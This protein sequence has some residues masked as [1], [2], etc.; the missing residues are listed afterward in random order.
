[1]RLKIIFIK[2]S[3]LLPLTAAPQFL[4]AKPDLCS[5]L[6]LTPVELTKADLELFK[7]SKTGPVLSGG[8]LSD[9]KNE[10]INQWNVYFVR[11]GDQ[12]CYDSPIK[13]MVG[14]KERLNTIAAR[15]MALGDVHHP[16]QIFFIC[17]SINYGPTSQLGEKY[18]KEIPLDNKVSRG[19]SAFYDI[20]YGML[21]KNNK[22]FRRYNFGKES[23]VIFL[24]D[25]DTLQGSTWSNDWALA[26]EIGHATLFPYLG[27]PKYFQEAVAD[28]KAYLTTGK[29]GTTYLS[30]RDV[31]NP[32]YK[33]IDDFFMNFASLANDYQIG[34]MFAHFLYAFS[35]K[36]KQLRQKPSV[37]HLI[38]RAMEL[39]SES[40]P[41]I[42][43]TGSFITYQFQE[44]YSKDDALRVLNFL[45]S[46][47]IQWSLEQSMP[48]ELTRWMCY[49]WTQHV[50][51][52][53]P[54]KRYRVYTHSND[55]KKI[56]DYSE[57]K[58]SR[59]KIPA[60]WSSCEDLFLQIDTMN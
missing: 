17:G 6:L 11:D 38:Y 40:S 3:I 42:K 47:T 35:E 22:S 9:D 7:K 10:L 12:E 29:T 55:G 26:H 28:F 44:R 4:F 27:V 39:L 43:H 33:T 37:N 50:G 58:L 14:L 30:E 51:V 8:V 46:A 34:A 13:L 57:K 18:D 53:G 41:H 60:Q 15:R 2:L 54:F 16:L 32:Q 24:S 36:Q 19:T 45:A 49:R 21:L 23:A 56:L 25:G 1:M 48:R 59:K 5:K 31:D 52:D 20:R